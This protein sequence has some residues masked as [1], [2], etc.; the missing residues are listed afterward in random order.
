MHLHQRS[1]TLSMGLNQLLAVGIC[2]GL[3]VAAAPAASEMYRWTDDKGQLHFTSDK[4]KIP[5]QFRNRDN[6]KSTSSKTTVT[7]SMTAQLRRSFM[8]ECRRPELTALT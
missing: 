5:R 1:I 3:L 6:A 4:S 2:A 7:I 8:T